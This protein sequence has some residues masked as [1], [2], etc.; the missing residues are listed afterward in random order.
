MKNVYSVLSSIA[1][2]FSLPVIAIPLA[3]KAAESNTKETKDQPNKESIKIEK[4]P[5]EDA[6]VPL[7][8]GGA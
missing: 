3:E 7:C 4:G 8:R 6:G 1:L 2:L 5:K